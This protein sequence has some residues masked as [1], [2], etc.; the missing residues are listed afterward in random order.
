M[1]FLNDIIEWVK[2][3]TLCLFQTVVL[4]SKVSLVPSLWCW[5]SSSVFKK[6]AMKRLWECH[7]DQYFY[8]QVI[9]CQPIIRQCIIRPYVFC[10]VS[11]FLLVMPFFISHCFSVK[12]TSRPFS[13]Y[14]PPPS[15][16]IP[17]QN[18]RLLFGSR[19]VISRRQIKFCWNSWRAH[20]IVQHKS[21]FG[22]TS[23]LSLNR[24]R[25]KSVWTENHPTVCELYL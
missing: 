14:H 2:V 25:R 24:F 11:I 20:Q 17:R 9:S 15:N 22:R 10:S 13:F 5:S 16:L 18:M 23:L 12:K 7:E 8:V 21:S 3:G 6:L 4:G 19:A 1:P